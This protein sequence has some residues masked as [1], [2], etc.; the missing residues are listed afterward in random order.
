M[1]DIEHDRLELKI[2]GLKAEMM[3]NSE[4]IAIKLS[5]IEKT[6][7]E[8][9]EQAKATNGRVNKHDEELELFRFLKKHKIIAGF[10]IFGLMKFYEA[11]DINEIFKILKSWL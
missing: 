6:G 3:A 2:Q 8:T 11:I 1:S 4:M 5:S 9:L 7:M 10:I